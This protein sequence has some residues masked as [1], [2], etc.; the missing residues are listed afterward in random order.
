MLTIDRDRIGRRRVAAAVVL[1]I[2][3]LLTASGVRAASEVRALWVVR[4]TLASPAAVETMVKTAQTA[5]FNTLLI[6]VRGRA[7]AYY[8]G[9]LEPR[10]PALAT[11]PG[12]DPLAAAISRA[13]E[14]GLQVHAWVNVN[15]VAGVGEMPSARDHIIYRHPE[16]LMVPRALVNDLNKIDSRS[17]EYL[18]RLA[19]YV[20]GRSDVEGLYLSPITS[21]AADYTIDVVR[22]IIQRYAVDGIHLDYARY[23][24]DDFDY[25]RE[26][27]AAFRQDVIG[28]LSPADRQ[29][30][31][32]RL[33]GEPTIYTMAFPERWRNFRSGRLTSLIAK[34]RDAVKAVR[35]GATI[36]AAVMPERHLSDGVYDRRD[37]IHRAGRGRADGGW[38]PSLVGGDRRVP[39]LV[40]PDCGQRPGRASSWR[41][42]RHP[43][44]VRQPH[45]AYAGTRISSRGRAG[46]FHAVIS[47]HG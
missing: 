10:P 33:S 1:V 46:R 8:S 44:F 21:G 29:K 27:L 5:G 37:D 19:R 25:G 38:T 22:D 32:T 47:S 3:A 43:F 39:P 24:T 2:A 20:R 42:R 45:R 28:D 23:P 12:F 34:V 18:G 35:P 17:P 16:W 26:A 13:H 15:L 4:T 9:G 6:Q 30:Y 7:D 41:R 11:Q 14:G 36:S 40:E 31:D